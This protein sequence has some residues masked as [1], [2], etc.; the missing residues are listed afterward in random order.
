MEGTLIY[1]SGITRHVFVTF[2]GCWVWICVAVV[3]ELK[4][5]QDLHPSRVKKSEK[6]RR[7]KSLHVQSRLQNVG[8]V[9]L[10]NVPPSFY[11]FVSIRFLKLCII[12]GQ[13]VPGCTCA[14]V[15]TGANCQYQRLVI[16]P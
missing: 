2:A 16:S 7:P 3:K 10:D 11:V 15:K 12:L 4:G 9:G 14:M 13:P 5:D 1:M 8:M 6:Q